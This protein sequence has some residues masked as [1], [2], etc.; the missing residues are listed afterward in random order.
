MSHSQLH[1]TNLFI[2]RHAWL[3]LWDKH[4]TTGRINQVTIQPHGTWVP[5]PIERGPHDMHVWSRS[6][7]SPSLGPASVTRHLQKH[8]QHHAWSTPAE[9]HFPL[10]HRPRSTLFPILTSFKSNLPLQRKVRSWPSEKTSKWEGPS[11]RP[12]P[13]WIPKRLHTQQV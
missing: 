12:I 6:K 10:K 4:M 7:M 3:N 13:Q 11:I 8:P 5:P 9:Q 1:S 2:L